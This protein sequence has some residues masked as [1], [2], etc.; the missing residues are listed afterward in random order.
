[1]SNNQAIIRQKRVRKLETHLANISSGTTLVFGLSDI[2]NYKIRLLELGFSASCIVGESVLP[3]ISGRISHFNANG[4]EKIRRDLPK[5]TVYHMR[6]H[7][8]KEWHGN[9]QVEQTKPIDMPYERYP[10]DFI[11]PPSVEVALLQSTDCVA[12]VTEKIVYD[13]SNTDRIIHTINLL[14]ELFGECHILDEAFSQLTFPALNR[15]NWQILPP[16]EYPWERLEETLRPIAEQ[17]KNSV[18]RAFLEI[19]LKIISEYQPDKIVTGK[20]G[21]LGYIVFGFTKA[22]LYIFE[23]ANYGNATYVFG[24]DWEELSRKTKGEIINSD[25]HIKRFV[26]TTKWTDEIRIFL[27]EYKILK[28]S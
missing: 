12:L 24:E 23:N 2:S 14:L 21:Y 11:P 5:E 19:R 9:E 26:H 18:Q 10:R 8:Y 7:T 16:G 1:M 20:A 4:K 6:E 17:A 28:P 27:N 13:P 25:S 3:K 22:N 15:L